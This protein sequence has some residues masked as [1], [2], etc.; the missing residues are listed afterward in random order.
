MKKLMSNH[1]NY[2][3]IS[4]VIPAVDNKVYN[5]VISITDQVKQK[6]KV[7]IVIVLNNCSDNF[8]LELNKKISEQIKHHFIKIIFLKKATIGSARNLGIKNAQGDYVV[9]M[10]SDCKLGSNYI[11]SLI[12]EIKKNDF[13]IARGPVNFIGFDTF[14]C[15]ASY[16]LKDLI[17]KSQKN[18]CYTPNLIIN[19]K[20]HKEK[21]F[22]FDEKF[23]HGEDSEFSFRM[24]RI[25]II[26]IHIRSVVMIH[27]DYD[28]SFKMFRKYLLYGIA[29]AYRFKKW[30]FKNNKLNFYSRVFGEIPKLN[31]I[32][33]PKIRLGILV[34]YIIRNI[35]VLYG[36]FK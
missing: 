10:D 20:L 8:F 32:L 7:E 19:M 6:Y 18:I 29:R 24:T 33:S 35:G 27:R 34:L 31:T 4:F 36:L 16:I 25:G 13:E 14:L 28:Q 3:I 17:Y 12:K 2:P 15:K 26:P 23:L 30:N 11:D 22:W 1:F 5:A 21:N 9:H